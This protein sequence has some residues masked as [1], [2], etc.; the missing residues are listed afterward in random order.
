[1]RPSLP[2]ALPSENRGTE[3]I[4]VLGAS[5]KVCFCNAIRSR[6]VQQSKVQD[7]QVHLSRYDVR[8]N[9]Y[10]ALRSRRIRAAHLKTH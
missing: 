5:V 2:G 6:M 1:M 9:F 7:D 4:T 10:L 8:L 3:L